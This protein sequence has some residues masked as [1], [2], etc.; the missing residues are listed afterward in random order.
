MLN[1][2][3]KIAMK[4]NIIDKDISLYLEINNKKSYVREKYIFDN[5]LIK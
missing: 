5:D 3:F 1:G 4:N 2:I